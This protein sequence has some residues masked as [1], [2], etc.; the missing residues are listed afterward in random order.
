[1]RER[2]RAGKRKRKREKGRKKERKKEKERKTKDR[3]WQLSLGSWGSAVSLRS[4]KNALVLAARAV[5]DST[6]RAHA[7]RD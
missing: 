4:A 5:M 2:K 6:R 3:G 1:M 7:T